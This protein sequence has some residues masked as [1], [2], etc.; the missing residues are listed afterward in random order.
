M[1]GCLHGHHYKYTPANSAD[2]SGGHTACGAA[3]S[4]GTKHA[5]LHANARSLCM[6]CIHTTLLELPLRLLLLIASWIAV[7]FNSACHLATPHNICRVMSERRLKSTVSSAGG[8][9]DR[10]IHFS[11][12]RHYSGG[13]T[14]P[15]RQEGRRQR[16]RTRGR[17]PQLEQQPP[18]QCRRTQQPSEPANTAQHFIASLPHLQDEE[19]QQDDKG[20]EQ[21]VLYMADDR[22]VP[23]ADDEG[24]LDDGGF[25]DKDPVPILI[26]KFPG[27]D[28]DEWLAEFH[29]LTDLQQALVMDGVRDHGKRMQD[30]LRQMATL[31]DVTTRQAAV[32]D[33]RM[34]AVKVQNNVM[35]AALNQLGCTVKAQPLPAQVPPT[36]TAMNILR[37]RIHPDDLARSFGNYPPNQPVAPPFSIT[38]LRTLQ[39][40][41]GEYLPPDNVGS[42]FKVPRP[43]FDPAQHKP[44]VRAGYTAPPPAYAPPPVYAPPPGYPHPYYPPYVQPPPPPPQQPQQPQQPQ[45]QYPALGTLLGQLSD[46]M[47]EA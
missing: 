21:P 23:P 17:Q 28:T 40:Q 5:K 47:E 43:A 6:G 8:S 12:D 26:S 27:T 37:D 34:R 18:Q 13:S 11:G 39:S 25:W 2:A 24:Y 9:N 16:N 33:V 38:A 46:V 30:G 19:L 32:Q 3:R 41:D 15:P 22:Y 31:V 45:P 42:G 20:D 36:C 10:N 4:E 35:K 7:A 29:S 1:S 14:E 44:E